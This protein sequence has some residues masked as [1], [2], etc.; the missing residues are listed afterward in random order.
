MKVKVKE[1][2]AEI[3]LKNSGMEL[4]VHDNN[5][6][7]LGDLVI[8]RTRLEWCDGRTRVGNGV[9]ISWT[10]FIE[11]AN[12]L[13]APAVKAAKKVPAKKGAAK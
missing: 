7:H 4:Q 11:F 12:G 5:D 9:Q 13:N 3:V 1:L 2:N 10:K 8:N 6:Q